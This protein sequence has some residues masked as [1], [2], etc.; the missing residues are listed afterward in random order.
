MATHIGIIAG[1]L[2]GALDTAFA[3]KP[4]NTIVLLSPAAEVRGD[5]VA[6]V[7][8]THSMPP[9][10]AYA[11]VRAAAGGPWYAPHSHA[12]DVRWSAAQDSTIRRRCT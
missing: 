8:N 2:T 11:T 12:K 1:D 9:E 10:D 7:T 4:G 5:N 3:D 6:I